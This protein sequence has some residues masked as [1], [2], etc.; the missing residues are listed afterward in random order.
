MFGLDFCLF[1]VFDGVLN[2][3]RD[4]TRCHSLTQYLRHALRV[5]LSIKESS[6]PPQYT[7]PA[8]SLLCRFWLSGDGDVLYAVADQ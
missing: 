6:L 1:F 7:E 8:L 4:A 5:G 3:W 2:P